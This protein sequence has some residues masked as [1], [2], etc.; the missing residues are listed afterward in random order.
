MYSLLT[1]SLVPDL[2]PVMELHCVVSGVYLISQT[3]I[4]KV[5]RA[6]KSCSLLEFEKKVNLCNILNTLPSIVT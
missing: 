2:S 4:Q 1:V 6:K 3:E 5:K